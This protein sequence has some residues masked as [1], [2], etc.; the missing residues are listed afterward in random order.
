MFKSRRYPH[1]R[2]CFSLHAVVEAA[3]C[4]AH[5]RFH[6]SPKVHAQKNKYRTSRLGVTGH[7]RFRY[8]LWRC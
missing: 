1:S 4:D 3:H 8:T 6:A 5:E 7:T 2:L